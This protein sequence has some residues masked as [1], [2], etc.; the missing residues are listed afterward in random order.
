MHAGCQQRPPPAVFSRLLATLKPR[1]SGGDRS[2][3][4]HRRMTRDRSHQFR[5]GWRTAGDATRCVP[6]E[7]DEDVAGGAHEVDPRQ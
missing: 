1:P 2:D 4:M 3:A 5:R 7:C 6:P